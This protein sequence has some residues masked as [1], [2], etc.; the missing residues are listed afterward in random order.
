[1]LDAVSISLSGMSAATTRLAN[2]AHNVAIS[3]VEEPRPLRTD[4]VTLSGGGTAAITSRAETPEPIRLDREIVEQIRAGHGFRAS[5]RV[6]DAELD[7][8]GQLLDLLA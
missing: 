1:M 6:L 8:R 2:S 7:R 4:Q 3:L 5:L